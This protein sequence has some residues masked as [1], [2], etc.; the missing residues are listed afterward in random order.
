M[1]KYLIFLLFEKRNTP[2]SVYIKRLICFCA[3][4]RTVYFYRICSAIQSRNIYIENCTSFIPVHTRNIIL[5]NFDIAVSR[6]DLVL[7]DCKLIKAFLI[8]VNNSGL[9]WYNTCFII[10]TW[11][12]TGK[13]FDYLST[14]N[15]ISSKF[16][17]II[18]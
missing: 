8:R 1:P 16:Q 4:F 18:A 5:C 11:T 6:N 3:A 12:G 9:V 17:N 15:I 7:P 14:Y 2:I 13:L 10:V